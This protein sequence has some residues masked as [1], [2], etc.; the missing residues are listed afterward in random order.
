MPFMKGYLALLILLLF[1]GWAYCAEPLV[2]VVLESGTDQPIPFANVTY[3]S[4]KF[5]GQSD[6]RGRIEF[7]VDSRNAILILQKNG[8]DSSVVELQDY[9][10]LLDVAFTLR[11][12]VRDL[13]SATVVGGPVTSWDNTRQVTVHKLEDAAGMRFDVTEHLSQM[14][15]MSGQK[16]FSSELFYDGSRSEEVAYHLGQLRVP[17]MR[18]LDVGFPGN[19]SVVNP[20]AL[21]GVELHDHYG[22]GPLGQGLATSVQFQPE[23]GSADQFQFRTAL[24]TTLREFYITGPWLFWDSFVFSARYLDPSM[25]KNMGEKFFTEFRKRDASCTDCDVKSSDPFTLSSKDFYLRLAGTD[26]SHNQWAVTGLYS[27]DTYAIRQDTATSLESVNSATIIQ[28]TRLYQLVGLEYNAASGLSWHAGM[29][30]SMASDTLRDTAGFRKIGTGGDEAFGN[31]I[32]G[33][34]ETVTTYS[35]GGDQPLRAE[36]LGAGTGVAVLYERRYLERSWPDFARTNSTDLS[37]NVFQANGRLSWQSEKNRTVLGVG[38]LGAT[39]AGAVQPTVSLDGERRFV[40]GK[41]GWRVFGNVAWRAD[42]D[43]PLEGMDYAPVLRSGASLKLGS[44]FNQGR[45]SVSA[46]GFGRYY[47]DPALPVPQAFSH[48]LEQVQP[49]YAWVSGVSATSEWRTLHHFALGMNLASVYGEYERPEGSLPWTANSRLDMVSHLRV[50]PRSD[51]LLSVILTHRAAWSR[52]LYAWHVNL[53]QNQ[54]MTQG[55]RSVR[56]A[57]LTTDLYRTDLRMN[58]D[59]KSKTKILLLENVR[60][61]V[62]AD[63]VF[64]PLESEALRFLGADN[65]RQRSVVVQDSDG[66]SDT[67]FEL[68]PFMAKG[69]GLYVQ[70]GV[71]GN[72][73]F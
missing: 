28:G 52:P 69:M 24:G 47:P 30:R 11:P 19:L 21:K 27:D 1:A 18:H 60:F 10:D 26:S 56:D 41:D 17:N 16:D 7:Q 9:P 20:H 72:F 31:F 33:Y 15:G 68:V 43:A 51:S 50:F 35:L 64:A 48:Y 49:D 54:L 63:N 73:G 8:Y 46:H 57:G 59:L 38:V 23:D 34:E 25:L 29:V 4:G 65:A 39:E 53:S 22:T 12:N 32:D 2:G 55:T 14:P 13:G 66:N 42:W 37:D 71:E 62:E 40:P 3:K 44:G 67:G 61:Y 5:L 70:F 6:S 36:I 58:L 45:L